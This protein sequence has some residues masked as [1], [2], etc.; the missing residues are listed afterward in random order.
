M[1]K[2]MKAQ[3]FE[4]GKVITKGSLAKLIAVEIERILVRLLIPPARVM[5]TSTPCL[6][7]DRHEQARGHRRIVLRRSGPGR[8]GELSTKPQTAQC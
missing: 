5:T 2:E 3:L 8:S 6:T 7:D 1:L 4:D